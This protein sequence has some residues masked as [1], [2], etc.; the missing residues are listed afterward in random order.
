M[1]TFILCFGKNGFKE[2]A[3]LFLQEIEL[4][5]KDSPSL[6]SAM[7]LAKGKAEVALEKG[8]TLESSKQALE[9]ARLYEEEEIEFSKDFEEISKLPFRARSDFHSLS[10]S[11]KTGGTSE[12]RK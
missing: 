9:L 1:N 7:F 12:R 11:P 2:D 4:I 8:D 10:E 3:A 5:Q 6:R